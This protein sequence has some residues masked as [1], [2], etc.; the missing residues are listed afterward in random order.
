MTRL[1][2]PKLSRRYQPTEQTWLIDWL[3]S[4]HSFHFLSVSVGPTSILSDTKSF[5]WHIF[6]KPKVL[7][8]NVFEMSQRRH[9]KDIFFEICSRCL[10]DV[11]QKTSFLRCFW[12][13][14]KTLQKRHLFWDVS[15]WSLK[16][17]SQWRSDW[18]LSETSHAGC[19][20]VK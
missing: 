9:R 14:L 10:E 4:M 5:L 17:L 18:D 7:A 11:T 16:Y 19:V 12:D 8:R 20:V 2:L 6:E 15:E 3:I 1:D 13:V